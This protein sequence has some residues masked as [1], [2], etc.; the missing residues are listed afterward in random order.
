MS[1]DEVIPPEP[2]DLNAEV[3]QQVVRWLDAEREFHQGLLREARG[4][5]SGEQDA[6]RQRKYRQAEQHI[7]FLGDA[8]LL[9]R[10]TYEDVLAE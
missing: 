7:A 8:A 5:A 10:E 3:V 4:F 6:E 2:P 9:F 1:D